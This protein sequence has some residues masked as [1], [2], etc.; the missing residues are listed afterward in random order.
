MHL[1]INDNDDL[2]KYAYL[3]NKQLNSDDD[4]VYDLIE[5]NDLNI[6]YNMIINDVIV[7]AN[8]GNLPLVYDVQQ[9]KKDGNELKDL[10]S[11]YIN[12]QTVGVNGLI[13]Y[14]MEMEY[15]NRYASDYIGFDPTTYTDEFILDIDGHQTFLVCKKMTI[16]FN[17]FTIKSDVQNSIKTITDLIDNI[18]SFIVIPT[19]NGGNLSNTENPIAYGNSL[20][21]MITMDGNGVLK[22]IPINVNP[23]YPPSFF[24]WE[25]Y[26]GKNFDIYRNA[27]VDIINNQQNG[28][29]ILSGLA[30]TG[31]S[32]FIS[33]AIQ[34]NLFQD[35]LILFLQYDL[36]DKMDSPMFISYI[37][38]LVYFYP[39]KRLLII[40]ENFDRNLDEAKRNNLI[41]K[42]YNYTESVFTYL[43]FAHFIFIFNDSKL[44]IDRSLITE[45]RISSTWFFDRLSIAESQELYD[46]VYLGMPYTIREPKTLKEIFFIQ[47]E[48]NPTVYPYPFYENIKPNL[49]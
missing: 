40:I 6:P 12:Y 27:M 41:Q 39:N 22:L 36:L 8:I 26:Y 37:S 38:S 28:V 24:G 11:V 25:I 45:K 17:N 49:I 31:K 1:R 18:S 15:Y 4:W 13:I 44:K 3:L 30:G 9:I 21:G 14:Y 33:R 34:E 7:P 46:M 5:L 16:I 23:F 32:R 20:T 29:H 42:M 48:L 35:K 2:I 43:D 47:E 19:Q 10:S